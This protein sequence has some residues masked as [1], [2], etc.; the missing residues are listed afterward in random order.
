MKNKNYFI[1]KFSQISEEIDA[2]QS[3]REKRIS[4]PN[5]ID[6]CQYWDDQESIPRTKYI[7]VL[8]EFQKW[9]LSKYK[10]DIS[11]KEKFFSKLYRS[12]FSS[13]LR[14]T[15]DNPKMEMVNYCIAY[16]MKEE[17]K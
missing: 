1:S 10:T 4:N 13:Y 3:N 11:D 7:K 12:Y 6:E 16:M 8:E 15:M 9:L 2:V 17:S 14:T 5:N